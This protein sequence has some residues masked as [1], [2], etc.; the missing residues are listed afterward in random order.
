MSP[1][2]QSKVSELRDPPV[3][4]PGIYLKRSMPRG[5]LVKLLPVLT[6]CAGDLRTRGRRS[7]HTARSPEGRR[8]L[9]ASCLPHFPS[10]LAFS[11]AL[12]PSADRLPFLLRSSQASHSFSAFSC[13]VSITPPSPCKSSRG[14]FPTF[15]FPH[16]LDLW[17]P[18]LL[19]VA[20]DFISRLC[21]FTKASL[22]SSLSI[23]RVFPLRLSPPALRAG[24]EQPLRCV[25]CMT[26]RL[27]PSGGAGVMQ[28]HTLQRSKTLQRLL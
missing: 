15:F 4:L 11:R 17:S 22:T 26:A 25:A 21:S 7:G 8:A 14:P 2:N 18:V 19:L 5:R 12:V 6:P 1:S 16:V 28:V 13:H 24:P 27:P 20:S 9:P 10:L 23:P 3:G